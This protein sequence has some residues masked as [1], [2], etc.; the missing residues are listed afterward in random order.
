MAILP[1]LVY[2][3]NAS[4]VARNPGSSLV[5]FFFFFPQNAQADTELNTEIQ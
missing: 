3:F 5:F 1:N 4:W 2:R